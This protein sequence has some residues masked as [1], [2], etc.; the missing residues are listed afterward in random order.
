[1]QKILIATLLLCL[2]AT[3]MAAE[4]KARGFY[5]GGSAGVTSLEDDG[6]ITEDGN[7][8]FD[9][10]DT[11]VT[12]FGGYKIL[13]YLAVEA[14]Y[15]NLGSYTVTGTSF[16]EQFD[17]DVTSLSAHVV[18]IIPFGASGWELFGQ[19]GLSQLNFDVSGSG[20]EDET[21]GSAGIGVRFYPTTNLGIS[22]QT[23]AYAYEQDGIGGRTYDIGVVATQI[24][25]N[26]IF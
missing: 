23:D 15:S 17:I 7:F 19:L 8:T 5:I 21:A 11:A 10:S 3:A 26:Y 2:S 4:Q 9:D 25:I 13:K 6:F 18:G 24:G 14:R 20:D 12:L 16:P 22:L 1:M